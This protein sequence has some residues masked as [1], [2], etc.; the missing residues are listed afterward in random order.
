MAKKQKIYWDL[1]TQHKIKYM[2]LLTTSKI[3]ETSKQM[4]AFIIINI[5]IAVTFNELFVI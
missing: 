1:K 5:I 3:L 4:K 2:Q